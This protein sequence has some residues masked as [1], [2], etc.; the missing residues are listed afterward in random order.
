MLQPTEEQ[1]HLYT[2]LSGSGL[3]V[4]AVA[5]VATL[6]VLSRTAGRRRYQL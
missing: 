5:G 2:A 3:A 4:V 1:V 6:L